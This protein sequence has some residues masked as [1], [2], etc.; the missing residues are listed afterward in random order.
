MSQDNNEAL[1]QE[2]PVEINRNQN[3]SPNTLKDQNGDKSEQVPAQKQE[4]HPGN[5]HEM[6]LKPQ[7]LAPWY[8]GSNKLLN[9]VAIITGGDSG[10]GRS[11]AILFAREGAKVVISYLNED[12]DAKETQYLVE[13]EGSKAILFKADLKI[14][15]NCID[16]V[17]TTIKHYGQLDILVNNAGEQHA[18]EDILE[19]TEENFI[20]TWHTKFFSMFWITQQALNYLKEGSSIINTSSVTAYAGKDT[21]VDYASTNGAIVAFTRSLALQLASKKIRV[22]S[23]APGPIW[24]PL[25]PSSFGKDLSEEKIKEFGKSTPLGRPGQ[26]EEV[27]PSYVFLASQDSSYYTGQTLHPN[28]GKIVN[29]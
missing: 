7:Y 2:Q 12:E 17:E 18:T 11:V 3:E 1:S 23:V 24:T 29:A 27:A 16:L 8:K 28:G 13:K 20:N 5:E 6:K 19:I 22:N 26:P 15:Q 14:K 25:I 4:K 10:I 9:K 21:L